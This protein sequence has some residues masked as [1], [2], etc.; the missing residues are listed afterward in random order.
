MTALLRGAEVQ[1]RVIGALALRETRTRFGGHVLGYAW[2]L[3]EPLFWIATFYGLFL[4]VD[5][6]SPERLDVVSF[7]A[8]GIVPYEL[9]MKT[10]DRVSNAVSGNKALLFYPQVQPLDLVYARV[11]LELATYVVVLAIILGVN[12]LVTGQVDI[13]SIPVLV[14][15]LLLAAVLGGSLGLVLCSL[16]IVVPTIERMKGPVMRPLFWMSGIFFTVHVLPSRLREVMLWNPILHCTEL[17]RAGWFRGYRAEYASP[18]YVLCWIL[19][20]LFV[21]LTLERSVRHRIEVT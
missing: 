18:V 4:L 2:A 14:S 17:V 19:G 1:I 9:V 5:R 20:L 11:A 6:T 12:G 15:G 7:L 3:A 10:Q 8:T 13:G 16:Q 21:G